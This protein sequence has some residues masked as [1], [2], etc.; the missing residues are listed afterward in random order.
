MNSGKIVAIS[1][2]VVDVEFVSSHVPLILSALSITKN[3]QEYLLEVQV[4]LGNNTVRCVSLHRTIGLARGD[5]VFDLG[6]PLQINV[7]DGIKG[8][9]MSTTSAPLDGLEM[10]P[11]EMRSIYTLP[12]SIK[13]ISENTEVIETGVKVIDLF[14]PYVKGGKIG[15]LGGAGVGKTVLITELIHNIAMAHN[16]YSVFI[17]SGER[18]REGLELFEAMK[19]SGVISQNTLESRVTILFGGM[20]KTPS[21][22]SKVVHAGLS[23]AEYFVEKEK[24]D[25]LIFIDNI[26]RF[27]QA[28]S[29]ISTLLGKSPAN[30]GYQ[31]NLIGELGEVQDRIASTSNGS[32]TSVQAVYIPADD[33]NDP[34]PRALFSHLTSQVVLSREIAASGIYPAV[35]P[36]LSSSQELKISLVGKKHYDVSLEAKKLINEYKSLKSIISIFGIDDLTEQQKQSVSRARKILNFFSQPMFTAEKFTGKTGKFVSISDTI[37][38]VTRIIDGEF[39]KVHESKFHMIGSVDDIKTHA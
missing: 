27:V 14:T 18:T 10:S 2:L 23:V 30:A 34:A 26:F 37:Q 24:K 33:L 39:D 19:N 11:M 31:P 17:G 12:P 3:D 38:S 7:G 28:G 8:R 9:V 36:L 5:I 20:G 32:I 25:V 4:H 6:K 16:G 1:G 13:D 21:E 35:D 22:R 15:F 29:E